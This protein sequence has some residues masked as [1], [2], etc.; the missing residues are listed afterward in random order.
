MN[1]ATKNWLI[2]DVPH[3]AGDSVVVGFCIKKSKIAGGLRV[4]TRNH[5]NMTISQTGAI[6]EH[7]PNPQ[8]K[9]T[10]ALLAS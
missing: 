1:T 3:F 4:I 6:L 7:L 2:P 8:K 9:K 5:K 10:G